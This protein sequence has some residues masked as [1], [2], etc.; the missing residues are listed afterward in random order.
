MGN[1]DPELQAIGLEVLPGNDED[2][3]AYAV[4]RFVLLAAEGMKGK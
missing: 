2:G 4:E 1:A 3:V